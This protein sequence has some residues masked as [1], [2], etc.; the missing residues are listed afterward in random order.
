MN[1]EA[2]GISYLM[3][4]EG[5][6]GK[7][8]IRFSASG[9]YAEEV[10]FPFF[11]SGKTMRDMVGRIIDD[12][13]QAR[14][15]RK[16]TPWGGVS[17]RYIQRTLDWL[18]ERGTGFPENLDIP[19]STTFLTAM[20]YSEDRFTQYEPGAQS[21]AI[22]RLL[23]N[24][25]DTTAGRLPHKSAFWG[26]LANRFFYIWKANENQDRG[27]DQGQFPHWWD[28]VRPLPNVELGRLNGTNG[29]GDGISIARRGARKKL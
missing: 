14:G 16:Q 1:V 4:P 28:D 29:T 18:V 21:K 22:S 23:L 17:T 26:V 15:R 19:M 13:V 25:I 9:K 5:I 12:C 20:V 6:Y 11:I 7:C 8:R 24:W 3:E 10:N 2:L 27:Q